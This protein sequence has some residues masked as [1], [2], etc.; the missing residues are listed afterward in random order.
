MVYHGTCKTET[1]IMY[2]HSDETD[3]QFVDIITDANISSVYVHINDYSWEFDIDTL[4]D[5]E[6]IK[7]AVMEVVHCAENVE[8]FIA[9]L[10]DVL[11]DNFEDILVEYSDDDDDDCALGLDD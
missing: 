11:I 4:T 2:P 5:Y 3:V 7:F 1:I 9:E 8:D 10:N 6:R